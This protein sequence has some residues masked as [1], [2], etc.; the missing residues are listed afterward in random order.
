M[1]IVWVIA[2][3]S[4]GSGCSSTRQDRLEIRGDQYDQA[5]DA[6]QRATRGEGMPPL[7]ADRSGGVIESRPRLAGSIMEPWRLDHGSVDQWAASTV[8]KQRRRVR[9]EFL[10]I[11]FVPPESFGEDELV[12]PPVP[13]S[14]EDLVRTTNLCTFDGPIEVRVWVWIEREQRAGL[15]RSTW[16]RQ[17]RSYATNPLDTVTPDDGTTRSPGV[18]TPVE[19]DVVM[20]QRL[21]ADVAESLTGS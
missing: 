8:H 6:A 18:W 21:L 13:G 14:E 10:P 16:T 3:A 4:A 9:F 1:G 17:G 19:R 7:L 2:T 12:G 5:F 15:R 11:E 20:E